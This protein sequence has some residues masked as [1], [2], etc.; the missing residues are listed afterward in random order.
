MNLFQLI[1]ILVIIFSTSRVTLRFREN[2]LKPIE[3]IFWLSLWIVG[4]LIIL[5]PQISSKTANFF[6]IG[7]GADFVIYA[8][9]ILLF[10]LI[11]RLYVKLE[12]ISRKLD[13]VIREISS[14]D[15]KD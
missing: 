15:N 9:I 7:R 13:K 2:A 12:Y 5:F 10:Y 6:G 14:R 11:Y 4:G 3:I 1:L 8:S